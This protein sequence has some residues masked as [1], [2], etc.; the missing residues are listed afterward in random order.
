[1]KIQAVIYFC[2]SVLISNANAASFQ[3]EKE[4]LAKLFNCATEKNIP[5][6]ETNSLIWLCENDS[7]DSVLQLS[8][9]FT[10]KD[11]VNTLQLIMFTNNNQPL[12]SKLVSFSRNIASKYAN[13][14]RS[15][16]VNII[17]SCQTKQNF[18]TTVLVDVGCVQGPAI[19]ERHL[20]VRMNKTE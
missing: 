3:A 17:K 9:K 2:L 16:I 8:R 20:I 7:G 11:S 12:D 14:Y 1:M 18:K 15:D 13:Q 19:T 6:S 4:S 10:S 5:G